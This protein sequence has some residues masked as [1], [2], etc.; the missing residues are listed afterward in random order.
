[1]SPRRARG[2]SP[3]R[4]SAIARR[5]VAARAEG[6]ADYLKRRAEIVRAAA[7]VFKQRGFS[8][9]TLN[10]V[11]E[12][13]GADRASL[14]YYVASKQ[15]LFDEIVG[16]AVRV[17]L[18][19]I[20]ELQAAVGPAPDKLRRLVE[21]LMQSYADY[22]PVL[23]VLIQENLSRVSPDRSRWAKEIRQINREYE[24]ALIE[25]VQ[26]GQDAGTISRAVPAWQVAYGII[27]MVAWSNRW[28]NP[29]QASASAQEIGSQ[30]ADVLLAGLST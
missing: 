24:R 11:A 10:D 28:F 17:N 15:E 12:A 6:R 27:G 29:H 9:T 13:M 23:Y 20:T 21:S 2:R 19:T 7:D 22:Y 3:G 25:I 26:S 16:E 4:S 14:Y 8:A 30:F 5:R 18:A 1:M